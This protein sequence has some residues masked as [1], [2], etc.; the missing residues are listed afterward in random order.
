MSNLNFARLLFMVM[1][2]S[3]G[4]KK[5]HGNLQAPPHT[6]KEEGW[7]MRHHAHHLLP[8]AEKVIE[9]MFPLQGT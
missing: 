1:F 6:A 2:L 7:K 4:T 8:E 5:Q 3:C 9:K